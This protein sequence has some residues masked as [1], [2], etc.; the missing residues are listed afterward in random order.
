MTATSTTLRL[1][2]E[3]AAIVGVEHVSDDSSLLTPFA[4]DGVRPMA[5]VAPASAEE[6]SA[7]LKFANQHRLAVTTSGGFTAQGLGATP[8]SID[9]LLRTER[10]NQVLH[11]DPGDLTVGVGAGMRDSAVQHLVVEHNLMLPL[12][13]PRSAQATVGRLTRHRVCRTF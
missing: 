5:S 12:D 6:I 7:I 8:A 4:I 9:I 1:G 3:S 2:S 11:Y 10:L 13:V